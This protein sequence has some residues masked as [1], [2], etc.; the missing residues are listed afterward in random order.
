MR[1]THTILFAAAAM[2]ALIMSSCGGDKPA[3]GE[4]AEQL[5]TLVADSQ[6]V[7][8]SL[9]DSYASGEGNPDVILNGDADGPGPKWELNPQI[10]PAACHRSFNNSHRMAYSKIAEEWPLQN[11]VNNNSFVVFRSFACSGASI[12]HGIVG[13]QFRAMKECEE[14]SVDWVYCDKSQLE[15]AE[16]FLDGEDIIDIDVALISIGG[17]DLGFSTIIE[18]CITPPI[19][20][21]FYQYSCDGHPSLHQMI[22]NGCPNGSPNPF[23]YKTTKHVGKKYYFKPQIVGMNSLPAKLDQMLSEVQEKLEPDHIVL[24]G[25]PDPTRNSSGNFCH[26]WD[27]NFVVGNSTAGSPQAG[28]TSLLFDPI[29]VPVGASAKQIEGKESQWAFNSVVRPL[30][31]TLNQ[32]ASSAGNVTYLGGM[33]ELTQN[34]GVCT[35]PGDRWFHS[36]K[37]SHFIQGDFFGTLHPNVAGHQAIS[38]LI[39]DELRSLL[40]LESG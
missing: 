25:F 5:A 4:T 26:K 13:P 30:N 8:V 14:G 19:A 39:A 35:N 27:D 3:P 6:L 17:N 32:A 31:E 37:D 1:P 12:T 11:N 33:E 36:L 24:V 22:K 34:H 7:I 21:P 15:M 9:G 2:F 18:A 10:D 28:G 40:D 29:I 23:C 16:E 38:E 20:G